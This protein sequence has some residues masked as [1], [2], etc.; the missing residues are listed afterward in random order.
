[1]NARSGAMPPNL[2]VVTDLAVYGRFR[3]HDSYGAAEQRF[4]RR[5][6]HGHGFE[7]ADEVGAAAGE[8]RRISGELEVGQP[9][10]QLLEHH[11]Q[12]Q[13]GERLTEAVVRAE[14]ERDVLV[15]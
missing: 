11:A 3:D 15:R 4:G 7:A 9:R 14:A 1:M 12:L 2:S 8:R 5:E 13:P 6:R 10:Q